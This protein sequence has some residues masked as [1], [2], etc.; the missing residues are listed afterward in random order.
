MQWLAPYFLILY[1]K[2]LN[3]LW[4]IFGGKK[5]KGKGV[6]IDV[7]G[8]KFVTPKKRWIGLS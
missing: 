6:F 5:G 1:A 2:I 7:S 8:I 4:P 3:E